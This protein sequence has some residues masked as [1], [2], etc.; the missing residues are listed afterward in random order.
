M[1]VLVTGAN[2]FIGSNL[3]SRLDVEDDIEVIKFTRESTIDDLTAVLSEVDFICH[4]AGVNRPQDD[5][6][7]AKVNA[8]LTRILCNEVQ[9][10]ER[11][12]PILFTSSVHVERENKYGK[13][14]LEAEK[15]LLKYSTKTDTPVFI[16][17]LPHVIGKWCRPNYNSVVSTFCYNIA[18]NM[19][20]QIDDPEYKLNLVYIDDFIDMV[21]KIVSQK[22]K[23][24]PF[25]EVSKSYPISVGG[26]AKLLH[27]FKASRTSLITEPVGKGLIRILYSTYISYLPPNDFAY[28]LEKHGDDR[29]IFVEFLKTKDSGQFSYFTAHPGITRGSHYHHT[30]TEKFLVVK[31]KAELRFRNILTNQ[32]HKVSTSAENPQVIETIPGWA[33]DITNIGDDEMI[34]LLWANE[35]FDLKKPDTYSSSL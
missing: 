32:S 26:L 8:D 20:I 21:L 3:V 7:F 22:I 9:K 18:R 29:G 12:I 19:P 5:N 24:G 4:T 35:I 2:G 16:F 27:E 34:V 25:C 28:S 10:V 31:G 17:R 33:H 11:H 30:K 23:C 1:K 6:E 13:S 14:K 15:I